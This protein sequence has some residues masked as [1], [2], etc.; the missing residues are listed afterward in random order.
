MPSISNVDH[1][2]YNWLLDPRTFTTFQE[3][4][5]L[6]PTQLIES[7]SKP[8]K[9]FEKIWKDLKQEMSEMKQLMKSKIQ[10]NCKDQ[11]MMKLKTNPIQHGL[12]KQNV[13]WTHKN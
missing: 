13:K 3:F 2:L 1:D 8:K 4:G 6:N 12:N 5:F 10:K 11:E 9:R 7:L